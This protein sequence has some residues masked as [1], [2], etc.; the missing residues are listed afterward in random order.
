MP[1]V[2][3]AEV[4]QPALKNGYAVAGLV[5][6]GWEDMRAFVAAAEA[7]N[8]PLILQAGPGCREHTPLP[9]LGKMFVHLAEHASVP[10]V[11]HLDHGYAMEEC[12]MALECGFTSV[13]YDGSRKSLNQNI[14]ETAA[15]AELAHAQ[16]MSCEGEI[17]FVGYAE[18]ESS[19]GT[20]PDEAA[21]FAQQTKVDAMAISVGNVHLQTDA[22]GRLDEE[23]IRAIEA[24]TNVPLVIHGGSGVPVEQRLSLALNTAICKY[25]IGTEL[26]QVFG[27]ALRESVN[28]DASRFDRVSILKDTH[29]PLLN[30]TR[31]VLQSVTPRR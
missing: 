6:L 30:A 22:G 21:Q 9:I 16:G 2:T 24:K 29:E 1:L 25:N 19:Q 15:I 31:K 20:D 12:R 23:R 14:E 4:L 3:L 13:M 18:G 10:V 8:V 5:T 7:E 11:A 27:Q 17:G 28:K 26:R